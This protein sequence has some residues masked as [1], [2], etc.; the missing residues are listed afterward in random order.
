MEGT[1]GKEKIGEGKRHEAEDEREGRR[2]G[3][4]R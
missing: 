3:E 1:R 2:E 4:G